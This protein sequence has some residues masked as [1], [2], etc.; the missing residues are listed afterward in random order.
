MEAEQAVAQGVILENVV[1]QHFMRRAD[2]NDW[3]RD[4][5][6]VSR[7]IREAPWFLVRHGIVAQ[8]V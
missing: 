7:E 8:G 1:E 6:I 4:A 3:I 2:G 5:S